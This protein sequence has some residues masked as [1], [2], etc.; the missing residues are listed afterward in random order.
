[1]W[2][3]LVLC[4]NNLMFIGYGGMSVGGSKHPVEP[5]LYLTVKRSFEINQLNAVYAGNVFATDRD[6]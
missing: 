4:T 3:T 5:A 1:M 2:S 6:I